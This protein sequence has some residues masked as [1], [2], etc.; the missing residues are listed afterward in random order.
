MKEQERS[1]T[2]IV[3]PRGCRLEVKL[4]AE[5]EIRVSGNECPRGEK[6]AKQELTDPRRNISSTV[7]IKHAELPVLP[8]KTA[9]EIPKDKI[10]E[11]MQV[12]NRTVAEAPVQ[13]GEVIIEDCAGS[14]VAVTAA[15]SM[16]RVERDD[17]RHG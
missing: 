10:M 5:A 11:V 4:T 6:Y 16:K 2:C 13:V 3:C 1:M 7:R 12:I 17:E 14:G 15:R 9:A 8:V